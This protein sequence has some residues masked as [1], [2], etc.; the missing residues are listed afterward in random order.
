M[1]VVRSSMASNAA[2]TMRRGMRES[3]PRL[4]CG[5][6]ARAPSLAADVAQERVE[7]GEAVDQAEGERAVAEEPAAVEHRGFVAGEFRSAP[8]ADPA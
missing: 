5:R 1:R 8:D 2:S 6:I 4:R 7:I 3:R